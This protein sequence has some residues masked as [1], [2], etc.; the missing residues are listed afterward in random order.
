MF[1][2]QQLTEHAQLTRQ[3]CEEAQSILQAARASGMSYKR[4]RD[5]YGIGGG[6]GENI[7]Y[8]LNNPLSVGAAYQVLRAEINGKQ[9]PEK[10]VP[11]GRAVGWSW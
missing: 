1:T 11:R 6:D 7:G 8:Y 10:T 5:H 4:L 3:I 9:I 2:I